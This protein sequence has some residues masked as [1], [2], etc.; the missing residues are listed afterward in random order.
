MLAIVNSKIK[1]NGKEIYLRGIALG[2]WLMMEGYMLGGRNM[3]ETKFKD[4]IESAL[5]KEKRDEFEKEFRNRFIAKTDAKTIKDLGFNCVRIPFNC[6]LV[7][8]NPQG[9]EFL[10]NAVKMFTDNKIYVI[11]DMHAVPGAQNKDWHSDS[12]GEALFYEDESYQKRFVK[13]WKEL[14]DAFKNEEYIAGYD[15][16]NEPVTDRTDIVEN[17]FAQVIDVIR[18]NN[19]KHI[20]FLEGNK[21]AQDVDFLENLAKKENV[22]ISIHFY[23]PAK[24]T[25]DEDKATTY[26]GIVNGVNWDEKYMEQYLAKYSK[27]NIPVYVGEFGVSNNRH[28]GEL[29]WVTDAISCFNKLGYHYTYWTYKSAAPMTFPDG[30]FQLFDK[31]LNMDDAVEFLKKDS[32]K[33]YKLLDTKNFKLNEELLKIIM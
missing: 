29:E 13:L 25:F 4:S 2:G 16:M 10:K 33:Y 8:N 7:E 1:N 24:F 30:L 27:F 17:V 12:L 32:E 3:A 11:L 6:R 18:N 19:D 26:P 5:G 23:E 14:S 21:W 31:S 22:A 15:I 28:R 20:I 9:L